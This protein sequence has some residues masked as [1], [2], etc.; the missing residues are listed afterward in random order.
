MFLCVALL[1]LYVF[2]V[3]SSVFYLLSRHETETRAS[4]LSSALAVKESEYYKL[5]H[6]LNEQMAY[7]SGFVQVSRVSYV[8]QG[9]EQ[10]LSFMPDGARA[11]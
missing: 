8:R 7:Q 10:T 1:G 3:Q 9:Q 5:T 6:L 2:F 4:S 11:R